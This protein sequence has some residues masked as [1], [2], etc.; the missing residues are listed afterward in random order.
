MKETFYFHLTLPEFVK[1]TRCDVS[2]RHRFGD[3]DQVRQ[4]QRTSYVKT[5]YLRICTEELKPVK[6]N[7]PAAKTAK[8]FRG[9][10]SQVVKTMA[11]A[12]I[13]KRANDL[14]LFDESITEIAIKEAAIASVPS[15][16]L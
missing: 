10:D 16:F 14:G 7:D 8:V 1:K 2:S 11:Y 12:Y 15:Y 5:Y 13:L 6:W 4:W 3:G 9:E